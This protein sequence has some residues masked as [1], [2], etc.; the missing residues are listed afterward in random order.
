MGR[1]GGTASFSRSV[2]LALHTDAMDTTERCTLT[3]TVPDKRMTRRRYF[4]KSSNQSAISPH[5]S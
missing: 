4:E 5:V 1:V 3:Y 2:F